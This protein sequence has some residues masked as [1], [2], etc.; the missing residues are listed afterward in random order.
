MICE[1]EEALDALSN[2]FLE[3]N[4]ISMLIKITSH[5]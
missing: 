1:Y 2:M 5:C 3:A 4:T